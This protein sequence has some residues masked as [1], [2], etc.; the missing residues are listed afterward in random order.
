MHGDGVER[1]SSV[2]NSIRQFIQHKRDAILLYYG[3]Q[4][5]KSWCF[6]RYTKPQNKKLL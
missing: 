2:R 3:L 6:V 1:F 4:M 5:E